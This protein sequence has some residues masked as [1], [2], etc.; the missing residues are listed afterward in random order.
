MNYF[1][2]YLLIL[3]FCAC[4]STVIL[5]SLKRRTR[6]ETLVFSVILLVTGI[7]IDNMHGIKELAEIHSFIP[8][9]M[10]VLPRLFIVLGFIIAIISYV[11]IKD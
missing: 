8:L 10:F 5:L 7:A 6:M 11:H 4:F 2:L 9:V 3:L 1:L